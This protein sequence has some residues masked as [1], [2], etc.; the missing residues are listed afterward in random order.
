MAIPVRPAMTLKSRVG[1]VRTLPSGWGI[2]Y[3]RTY[4][5]SCPTAVALVPVGYGDGYH[6][7]QSNKGT[8]LIRG[9][10]APILGRVCMDQCVVNVECIDGLSQD[11]E[12]VLIGCQGGEEITAEE[13]ASLV[14][15]ISY[16]V[17]CAISARVPRLYLRNGQVVGM[18]ALG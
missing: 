13:M 16:E 12:V 15:T 9:K 14:G 18:D 3:G 7:I 8:V 1:R 4:V 2:S 17:L 6:R 5:T 10:R 11:E